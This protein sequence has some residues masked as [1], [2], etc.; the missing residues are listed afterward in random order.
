LTVNQ[1]VAGS[2]PASPASRQNKNKEQNK[3]PSFDKET[4]ALWNAQNIRD[5]LNSDEPL[6]ITQRR[7]LE[8]ELSSVNKVLEVVS[9]QL[10]YQKRLID[11]LNKP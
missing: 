7:I 10:R 9:E 5:Y 6:N 2:S 11:R 8:E 4:L 1:R 3:M